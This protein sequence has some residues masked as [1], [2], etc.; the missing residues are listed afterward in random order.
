MAL[1]NINV[2]AAP[3]DKS[4][5]P[6]RDAFIKLNAMLA[7]LYLLTGSGGVPAQRYYSGSPL[8]PRSTSTLAVS[9]NTLYATLINTPEKKTWNRISL[10]VTAGV[11]GQV[12]LGM[13]SASQ[14]LP[15][16]LLLDAGVLDTSTG[17]IKEAAIALTLDP[18][19]YFAVAVFSAAPTIRAAAYSQ[20]AMPFIAVGTPGASDSQ[21]NSAFA[22]GV[23]PG[24]FPAIT[25][26]A[27]VSL[28][29]LIMLRH[30]V[31]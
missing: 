18:G 16:S 27:G 4:G 12:R 30:G 8:D 19:W 6:L 7:E 31:P 1:Q 24:A 11:A 28:V 23:L 3:N 9:A 10:E 22:F 5:D 25:R 15:A 13:Y 20:P 17:G 14:G 26:P 2:G 29:P 21:I